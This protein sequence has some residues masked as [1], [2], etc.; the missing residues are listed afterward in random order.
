MQ[1]VFSALFWGYFSGTK[2]SSVGCNTVFSC[3]NTVGSRVLNGKEDVIENSGWCSSQPYLI[4]PGSQ[5]FWLFLLL[6]NKL[7]WDL[8][9]SIKAVSVYTAKSQRSAGR[10]FECATAVMFPW[11]WHCGSII[12]GRSAACI[13]L[14]V[15]MFRLDCPSQASRSLSSCYL[16]LKSPLRLFPET[17]LGK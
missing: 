6:Y 4:M 9:R 15:L 13:G 2:L 11:Q 12:L 16:L 1:I 3:R 7:D 14:E 10:V 17:Q 8:W 5:W